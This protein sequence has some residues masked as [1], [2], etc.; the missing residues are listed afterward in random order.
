MRLFRR[1]ESASTLELL[2]AGLGNPGPRHERDRHNVGWMVV[3]ELGRRHAASF[4]SKFNGRI[5]DVRIEDHRLALLEPETYMNDSGRS[6]AAAASF[7]K[8]E[9]ANVLVVHDDVDLEFGRLQ[10]RAGGGTAGHN[11]LRSIAQVLGT[12]DFVR[13]RVGVG[14]PGRGDPHEVADFVLSPFEAHEDRDGIVARA[15]DA[16][17]VVVAEGLEE[18]QRRFNERS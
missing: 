7:Y 9:P 6:I 17:E 5:A 12:P 16:V 2:V 15:A 13:M 8:V 4:R 11:G 1:G 18:A 10:A 3:D 14:R